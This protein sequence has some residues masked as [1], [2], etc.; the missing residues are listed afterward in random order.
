MLTYHIGH[1]FVTICDVCD[2]VTEGFLLYLVRRI[3][4]YDFGPYK[5]VRRKHGQREGN[6]TVTCARSFSNTTMIHNRI[7]PIFAIAVIARRILASPTVGNG[8][9]TFTAAAK[10]IGKTWLQLH[11]QQNSLPSLVPHPHNLK[12]KPGRLEKR[13]RHCHKAL[14]QS[15]LLQCLGTLTRACFQ[16]VIVP[17][18]RLR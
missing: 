12:H 10:H 8:P 14:Q 5:H 15:I 4:L 3:F 16:R 11:I 1:M 13:L 6:S 9:G 17:S 2:A 18:T 7:T